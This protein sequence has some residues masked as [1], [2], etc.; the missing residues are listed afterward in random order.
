MLVGMPEGAWKRFDTVTDSEESKNFRSVVCQRPDGTERIATLTTVHGIVKSHGGIIFVE[1]KIEKGTKFSVYLPLLAMGENV[2]EKQDV[3]QIV[4]GNERILLVDDEVNILQIEEKKRARL[5]Y[6]I[7]TKESPHDAL[8]LFKQ[9]SEPFDLV[10][11]D[12][13]MPKMAGDKFAE[14]LKKIHSD[15][16]IILCTGFSEIMTKE[17]AESIGVKG[18]LMKPTTMRHHF[19]LGLS[20]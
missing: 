17:K 20:Y 12:M 19:L 6:R 18:F 8:A 16:P 3:S 14:N 7:T 13:T 5:G 10:I 1:S 15:T 9:Q 4:G 2:P 11:T